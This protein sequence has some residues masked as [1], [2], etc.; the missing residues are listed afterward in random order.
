MCQRLSDVQRRVT[1][2]ASGQS[3]RIGSLGEVDEKHDRTFISGTSFLAH[4][5]TVLDRE[6][7][8]LS[9]RLL[10]DRAD[11]AV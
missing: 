3:T 5:S 8:I 4:R 2:Q 7:A 9:L 1:A 11:R 6:D 10:S